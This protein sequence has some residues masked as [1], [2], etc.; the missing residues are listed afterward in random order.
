MMRTVKGYIL[1]GLQMHNDWL[2]FVTSV[3]RE[4]IQDGRQVSVLDDTLDD[5]EAEL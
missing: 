1:K 3:I 5:D 4:Q 2:I